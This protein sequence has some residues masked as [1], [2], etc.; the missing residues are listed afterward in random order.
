MVPSPKDKKVIGN[1]WVH[2]VKLRVN[3]TL[4]KYKLRV[5]AK[6]NDQIKGIDCKETFSLGVKPT[7]IKIVITLALSRD[8]CVRQLNVNNVFFNRGSEEEVYMTT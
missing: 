3:K 6:S 7:T 8:W 4:G 2:R 1:K 5:V